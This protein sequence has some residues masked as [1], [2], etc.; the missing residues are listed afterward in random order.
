[1]NTNVDNAAAD[2]INANRNIVPEIPW[3]YRLPNHPVEQARLRLQAPHEARESEIN[4]RNHGCDASNSA[5]CKA[6]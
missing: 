5:A 1:M 3:L 6:D 4:Q 2:I